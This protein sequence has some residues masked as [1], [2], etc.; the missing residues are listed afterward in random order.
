MNDSQILRAD[1]ARLKREHALKMWTRFLVE[2]V[3]V[4]GMLVFG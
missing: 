3:V 4:V 1:E 2:V